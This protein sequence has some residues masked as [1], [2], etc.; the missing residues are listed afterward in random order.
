MNKSIVA[1]IAT[2]KDRAAVCRDSIGCVAPQVDAVILVGSDDVDHGLANET[3]AIY[4]QRP[5]H[6]LSHKWQ[7]GID[8]ARD[9][10]ADAVLICGSDDWLCPDYVDEFRRV[11]GESPFEVYGRPDWYVLDTHD[12]EILHVRYLDG[13]VLGA[14]RVLTKRLLDRIGWKPYGFDRDSGLEYA[15]RETFG[16]Q[17]VYYK[18]DSPRGRVLSIKGPWECITPRC[19]MEEAR[20]LNVEKIDNWQAWL[21]G[22]FPGKDMA[23]YGIH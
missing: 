8:A 14:G 7:G 3:G 21:E 4:I 13:R 19:K 20:H 6:W 16:T 12:P 1:V 9:L 10:G 2:T 11:W 17:A 23:K 5:N 22:H 15:S 18:N